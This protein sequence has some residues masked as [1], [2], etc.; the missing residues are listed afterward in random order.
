[1]SNLYW[2]FAALCIPFILGACGGGTG[3]SQATNVTSPSQIPISGS[4]GDGPVTNATIT[5]VDAN[6][7][8]IGT[9]TSD[10][11]ASY[12]FILPAGVAMPVEIRATGGLD[13]VTGRMLDF[14]LVSIA[15]N[16]Q[17]T[18]LNISPLTTLEYE[19]SRCL[20]DGVPTDEA[21]Q[22]I[23]SQMSMGL[24]D[25]DSQTVLVD[26]S[27]AAAFVKA[28]EALGE[29]IRRSASLL[30]GS[31]ETTVLAQIGCDLADGALDGNGSSSPR[32]AAVVHANLVAV[33]IETLS[34]SLQVDGTNAL[35][36][37]NQS[38]ATI[39]PA[40]E[41]FTDDVQPDDNIIELLYKSIGI[42]RAGTDV[43]TLT[44]IENILASTSP[45]DLATILATDLSP[46]A[47]QTLRELPMLTSQAQSDELTAIVNKATLT[48]QSEPPTV[49]LAVENNIIAANDDVRLSWSTSNAERCIAG[50]DWIGEQDL[51]G[52]V[53]LTAVTASSQFS[54]TCI[55]PGGS[56]TA[57]SDVTVQSTSLQQDPPSQEPPSQDPVAPLTP[58]LLIT[59]SPASTTPGQSTTLNWTSSNTTNCVA[60]GGWSGAKNSSGSQTLSNLTNTTQFTIG[61]TAATGDII[62]SVTVTVVAQ[63]AP[64]VNFSSARSSLVSGE[65][66][67]LSWTATNAET[68]TGSGAWSGNK[69]LNGTEPTAA[70]NATSTYGLTCS[71]PGGETHVDTSVIVV[72]QNAPQITLTA[73]AQTIPWNS[74]VTLR[75]NSTNANSCASSGDWQDPINT[76]GSQSLVN[77]K[78]YQRFTLTC[79]GPGGSTA[80]TTAVNVQAASQPIINFTTTNSNLENGESSMLSWTTE[81]AEACTASADWSGSRPLSGS[82]N[83]GALSTTST[84][85]LTCSGEGGEVANTINV[86]VESP[87]PTSATLSASPKWINRSAST[88]L[89][90]SSVGANECQASGDW[91]GAKSITGSEQTGSLTAD[92]NYSLTCSDGNNNAVAITAVSLRQAILSWAAPTENSNGTPLTDLAGYRIHWGTTSGQY[93][94][95]HTIN[96]ANTLSHVVE[97]TPGAYYF[98][99]TSL[100]ESGTESAFSG[101][102]SKSIE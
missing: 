94:N 58:T 3:G 14:D 63:A 56:K 53:T 67:T 84:F 78:G 64:S 96:S 76:S 30:T 23:A 21:K 10:S 87:Q 49:S 95:T 46:S 82:Q 70:L 75:W 83:T 15:T 85:T 92:A 36:R 51:E 68:C 26:A 93:S 34:N 1:M 71:G 69:P 80:V 27:N 11:A 77:L 18:N 13:L 89:S 60:S 12:N 73:S 4:V 50:G 98:N 91:S 20:P 61:C 29:I 100:N 57:T 72:A 97:L 88:T 19:I 25:I 86:V 16:P 65:T 38:V 7:S 59:A 55:G 41:I 102:R 99:L 6:G 81:N 45:E 43:S 90:W 40:A 17:Q 101:E 8:E 5:I 2:R 48:R 44:E 9:T 24:G 31:N 32:V 74:G 47:A 39:Q 66:T 42:I 37:M 35:T 22:I 52:A 28:N 54:L 79:S 33:L 62:Q